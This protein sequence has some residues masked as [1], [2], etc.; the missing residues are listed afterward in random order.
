MRNG[1]AR[2]SD[3]AASFARNARI[4]AMLVLTGGCNQHRL[5]SR[6][7][8]LGDGARSCSPRR[9]RECTAQEQPCRSGPRPDNGVSDAGVGPRPRP[10]SAKRQATG[11]VARRGLAVWQS[12]RTIEKSGNQ[13]HDPRCGRDLRREGVL[14]FGSQQP[15]RFG[16]TLPDGRVSE[17]HPSKSLPNRITTVFAVG[18]HAGKGFDNTWYTRIVLD[19][20]VLQATTYCAGFVFGRFR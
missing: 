4:L 13:R 12:A 20:N 16:K 8:L 1:R 18:G 14:C 6:V 7:A 17:I 10:A 3:R 15:R 5:G 11:C 2:I 19:V 9:T